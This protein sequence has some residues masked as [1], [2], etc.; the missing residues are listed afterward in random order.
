MS[1]KRTV[2]AILV[3][4][5]LCAA[6]ENP[7]VQD[8]LRVPATVTALHISAETL[9]GG[10]Y[11]AAG[12]IAH[13]LDP[14]FS[15]ERTEYTALVP[16][17]TDRITVTA[18]PYKNG[19]V[20]YR[21]E[22]GQENDTGVFDFTGKQSAVIYVTV[23]REYMDATVYTILVKRKQ[24]AWL[25]GIT[26]T[27]DATGAAAQPL[28]PGFDSDTLAY[29]VV[30]SS[31]AV[32]VNVTG[33]VKP[34]VQISFKRDAG[35]FGPETTATDTNTNISSGDLSFN[36]AEEITVTIKVFLPPSE[37]NP[38][39][40]PIEYTLLIQRPG[41]VQSA[42]GQENNFVL[43]DSAAEHHYHRAGEAV[44]FTV[45]PPFGFTTAA[46]YYTP[47]GGTPREITGT[48]GVYAFIMPREDVRLKGEWTAI[49]PVPGVLYVR[50][51]RDGETLEQ[52]RHEKEVN[53]N[54]DDGSSWA[55]AS[56]DL[57]DVM[58]NKWAPGREIW[59]SGGKVRPDWTT[60]TPGS[61]WAGDITPAQYEDK[62]NRAFVLRK[63][64]RIYGGFEGTETARPSVLPQH[65]TILSGDLGTE[66]NARHVLVAAGID[67][68]T[69][70]ES[71]TIS[72]GAGF[73][74]DITVQGKTI[75][76]T[77]GGGVYTVDCTRALKFLN[78]TIT[79]NTAANGGGTYNA[80]SGPTFDGPTLE[81][82]T[83]SGNSSVSGTGGIKNE[84]SHVSLTNARI[85]G[86]S[87]PQGAAIDLGAYEK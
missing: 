39:P 11:K 5:L 46:V 86:N 10:V 78:V 43:G 25:N 19:S 47:E 60:V 81:G 83:I 52:V 18:A 58:D 30:V 82:V 84:N 56:P 23:N 21:E 44:A 15:P 50:G 34:G 20:R 2:F 32:T 77:S 49:P 62:R 26:V 6:C 53:G 31:T 79:G 66:G 38:D 9:D 73:G 67:Q 63:G 72:G 22:G 8:I 71:L 51:L 13:G 55:N 40:S 74:G 12:D 24:P 27:S 4:A 42:A 69:V 64:V 68:P 75:T 57:Q 48:G 61:G 45:K 54:T 16:E 29:T 41:K 33:I 65:K 85:T 17:K 59:I 28:S 80:N 76:G 37:A 3:P 7:V 14:A 70:I 1:M 35:G 36:G 87:R